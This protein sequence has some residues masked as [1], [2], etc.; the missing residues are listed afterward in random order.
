MDKVESRTNIP[1]YF[2]RSS[3]RKLMKNSFRMGYL[4]RM[5]YSGRRG[6]SG[7]LEYSIDTFTDQYLFSPNNIFF[8]LIALSYIVVLRDKFLKS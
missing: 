4:G 3:F 6:Y 1:Y 5:R 2:R 7:R 8:I